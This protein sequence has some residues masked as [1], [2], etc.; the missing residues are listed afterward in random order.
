MVM[1]RLHARTLLGLVL[2][3]TVAK[4]CRL[5]ATESPP[6][7]TKAATATL[8]SLLPPTV[9]AEDTH[10]APGVATPE[11]PWEGE[12]MILT[13]VFDNN[14]YDSRLQTGWGFAAW[15]ECS[16]QT[17]LFDTGADG[18][19]LLDNMA[20]LGLDFKA[21][22]IVV[23]SHIHG[24]HT[25]GLAAV[26]AANPQVTVYLPKVFPTGFKEQVRAAGV[27]LVELDAPIEILPGL[28]SAGQMATGIVEQALVARTEKGLVVVTGCAH[29]GVDEMVARAKQVG[30][31]EIALVIGGFHL[32]GSSGS[33]WPS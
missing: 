9:Q 30:R 4:G 26:L 33:A 3:G 16:G 32:S 18:V 19:V 23:L 31:D 1:S 22:G 6:T 24:D 27:A 21:I 12:T 10:V 17:V 14:P 5:T 25:G 28:W 2:L 8:P 29:P 15:L 13:V 20:A 11:S 7:P